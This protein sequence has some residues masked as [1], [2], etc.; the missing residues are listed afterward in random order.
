MPTLA[1]L[2]NIELEILKKKLKG[3]QIE[4]EEVK[5]SLFA[6]GMMLYIENSRDATKKTTRLIS[7]AR[8]QDIKLIYRN[9]LHFYTNK[10]PK[11]E[12]KKTI[13]FAVA[14]KRITYL[15]IKLTK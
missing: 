1:T 10:V 9:W 15:G 2:F 8:L 3:I 12:I 4:K 14:S 7:L 6:D 13:S 11:R 5:L